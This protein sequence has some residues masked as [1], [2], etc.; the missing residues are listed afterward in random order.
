MKGK[1]GM[2]KGPLNAQ[3]TRKFQLRSRPQ[4]LTWVLHAKGKYLGEAKIVFNMKNVG[5][6]R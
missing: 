5:K 6:N 4:V 1:C 3:I 2:K